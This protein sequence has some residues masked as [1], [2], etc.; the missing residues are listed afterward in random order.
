[1]PRVGQVHTTFVPSPSAAL[2]RSRAF[3]LSAS[4]EKVAG[5]GSTT[6]DYVIEIVSKPAEAGGKLLARYAARDGVRDLFV[7]T[8]LLLFVLVLVVLMLVLVVVVLVLLRVGGGVGGGVDVDFD[9]ACVDVGAG[10]RRWS[11]MLGFGLGH[12]VSGDVGVAVDVG[13]GV[14]CRVAVSLLVV[15]FAHVYSWGLLLSAVVS[16]WILMLLVCP[17]YCPAEREVGGETVPLLFLRAS[18][19]VELHPN[20]TPTPTLNPTPTVLPPPPAS[21]LATREKWQV[22]NQ[23]GGPRATAIANSER[24]AHMRLVPWAGVAA[25]FSTTEEGGDAGGPKPP[26]GAAYCFLPLPVVTGLPV[27]VNGYF[28]LSSNRQGFDRVR[29]RGERC[30][31]F[32]A[33]WY[34]RHSARGL[35]LLIYRS[36]MVQRFSNNTTS[37]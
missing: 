24:A 21:G 1:M 10:G 14:W 36:F 4:P 12:G 2:R 19:L 20:T 23:L 9:V 29:R 22:C 5:G 26:R 15:V 33:F 7:L 6:A 34:I 28:E 31:L 35:L 11:R 32:D 30:C 37:K 25:R 27:H 3:A 13:V 18:Q 16:V 8:E 17:R